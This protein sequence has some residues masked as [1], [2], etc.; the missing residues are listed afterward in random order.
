MTALST[1]GKS[2]F[3]RISFGDLPL[4]FLSGVRL[5]SLH[6]PVA[7]AARALAGRYSYTGEQG[8]RPNLSRARA[9]IYW[10]SKALGC[11][12]NSKFHICLQIG[13]FAALNDRYN[14]R[15]LG[16]VPGCL[17]TPYYVLAPESSY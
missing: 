6:N 9:E 15:R 13:I 3:D 7:R 12:C 16:R 11:I 17:R 1:A 8:D 10:F 4:K 2:M 14:Q 5:L